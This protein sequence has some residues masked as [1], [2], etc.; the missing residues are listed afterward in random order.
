MVLNSVVAGFSSVVNGDIMPG[1]AVDSYL[2]N[3]V[4]GEI[5]KEFKIGM[6]T[7]GCPV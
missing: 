6:K 3:R 7:P 5:G 4:L 2:R 1:Q